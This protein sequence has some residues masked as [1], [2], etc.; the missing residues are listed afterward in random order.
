M[1]GKKDKFQKQIEFYAQMAENIDST[2]EETE[3]DEEFYEALE[4]DPSQA[5]L[6]IICSAIH[7]AFITL[8]FKKEDLANA[9]KELK[10]LN[11][12]NLH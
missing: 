11:P 9:E 7:T 6:M 3:L 12:M 5:E 1:A 8:K 2:G 10:G 4:S